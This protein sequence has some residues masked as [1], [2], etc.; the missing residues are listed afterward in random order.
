MSETQPGA[1]FFKACEKCT[2]PVHRLSPICRLC[3]TTSP[4]R[5]QQAVAQADESTDISAPD[6]ISE[7]AG[8]SSQT[9]LPPVIPAESGASPPVPAI[10]SAQP[11]TEVEPYIVLRDFRHQ[12][13][14]VNGQFNSGQVLRDWSTIEKLKLAGQPIA[15]VA[16]AHGIAC[17]PAC[18][19]MFSWTPPSAAQGRK[20][21]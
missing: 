13:G 3:G 9:T 12:F 1:G 2:N 21:I 11:R 16:A 10:A 20:T 8:Q 15:P 18:G 5:T 6:H 4:W 19:T 17:C 14:D 7:D